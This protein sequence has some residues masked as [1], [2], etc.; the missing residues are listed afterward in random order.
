[1]NTGW[2]QPPAYSSVGWSFLASTG[3]FELQ[4]GQEQQVD[5]AIVAATGIDQLDAVRR[6]REA[7]AAARA[8]HADRAPV[9][10]AGGPYSGYEDV[11]ISFDGS[12][13]T[14]P[15]GEPLTY[16]WQF[17]DGASATG[18]RPRHTFTEP[19]H[20]TAALVVLD[21]S[22][23]SRDTTSVTV[24][25]VD[26]ASA[27]LA[28]SDQVVRLQS[29][30]PIIRILLQPT[31]SG[32]APEEIVVSS[33]TLERDDGT[34]APISAISDKTPG[35]T[36]ANGDDTPEIGILYRKSDVRLLLADAPAGR[37]LVPVT[38]RGA[39]IGGGRF[40]AP[41]ILTVEAGR[42]HLGASIAPNP[43]NPTSTITFR[44]T[45]SGPTC[46]RVFDVSGRLARVLLDERSLPAGYH[47]IEIGGDAPG[48]RLSSGVYFYR[49][50]TQEGEA[51]GR[52]VVLK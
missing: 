38:I 4:P 27:W 47:D 31:A 14:D 2:L 11:P 28:R 24:A 32:F 51:S 36:D 16:G 6:L 3:P 50:E 19:G 43:F 9:A 25:A 7:A 23:A 44:T 37:S 34:A 45:R 12:G 39:L 49:I 17:G 5:I 30:R 46:V 1:M 35:P 52:F 15:D 18:P 8:A 13:S 22:L 48:R 29:A 33:V 42:G 10:D 20:Y 26:S 41:T 40:A 21:G